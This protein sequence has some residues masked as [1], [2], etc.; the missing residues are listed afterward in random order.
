M[1]DKLPVQT[2]LDLPR[3][4]YWNHRM[5][6]ELVEGEELWGV[7]EL[8]YD[9]DDNVV[10]WTAETVTPHGETVEELRADLARFH[11]TAEKPAFDV[12]TR[13]WRAWGEEA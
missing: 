3:P 11:A 12:D 1:T 7:R 4:T 5:T 13:T 6:V 10:G 2:R 8:Y 9:V